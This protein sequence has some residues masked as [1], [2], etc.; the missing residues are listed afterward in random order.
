MAKKRSR[1]WCGNNEGIRQADFVGMHFEVAANV[2]TAVFIS[3][4]QLI[5]SLSPEL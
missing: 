4:Y 1:V 2:L 5:R 3:G